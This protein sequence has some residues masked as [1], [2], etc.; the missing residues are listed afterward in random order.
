MKDILIA[1]LGIKEVVLKTRRIWFVN[2]VKILFDKLESLGEIVEVEATRW[3]ENNEKGGTPGATH[4]V[5]G[6]FEI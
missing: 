3:D 5:A 6:L 2:N 4:T 1:A